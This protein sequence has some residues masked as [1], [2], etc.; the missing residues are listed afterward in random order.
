MGTN[1][2]STTLQRRLKAR[3]LCDELLRILRTL[4]PA[5]NSASTSRTPA[6]ARAP[7]HTHTSSSFN[8]GASKY[9]KIDRSTLLFHTVRTLSQM[10]GVSDYELAERVRWFKE[11]GRRERGR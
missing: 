4:L 9:D 10:Q 8:A 2:H 6:C 7:T 5:L 3:R 11:R 1:F